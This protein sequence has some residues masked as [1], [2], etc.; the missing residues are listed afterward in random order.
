MRK[1]SKPA[2]QLVS[3][4]GR[5]Q[6]PSTSSR[7]YVLDFRIHVH[8]V[9]VMVCAIRTGEGRFVG[10]F[11][12][13]AVVKSSLPSRMHISMAS[14]MRACSLDPTAEFARIFGLRTHSANVRC[15]P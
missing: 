3:I 8:A 6:Y 13:T 4:R 10:T 7:C 12:T 14:K 15:G 11:A 9:V 1:S 2:G 5:Y